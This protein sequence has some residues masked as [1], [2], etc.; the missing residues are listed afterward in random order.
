MFLALFFINDVAQAKIL[1]RSVSD[2]PPTESDGTV[3]SYRAT[4]VNTQQFTNLYTES[5]S[6]ELQTVYTDD[7]HYASNYM[8]KIDT[9]TSTTIATNKST[10]NLSVIVGV[11]RSIVTGEVK[12]S[13]TILTPTRSGP[14]LDWMAP[15]TEVQV[16]SGCQVTVEFYLVSATATGLYTFGAQGQIGEGKFTAEDFSDAVL[17][18]DYHY[19]NADDMY[20]ICNAKDYSLVLNKR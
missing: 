18:A 8:S 9:K 3:H 15:V 6:N 14:S 11:H 16:P 10:A 17:K 13:S 12:Y 7:F 1:N 2:Y 20:P 19:S 4:L 5:G